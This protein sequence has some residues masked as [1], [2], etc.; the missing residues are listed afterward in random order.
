MSDHHYFTGSLPAL[1]TPFLNGELDTQALRDLV[2]W[3]LAEGSHGIVPCGTTGEAPTLSQDEYEA[4]IAICAEQA[5]GQFPV[6]AGCGANSTQKAL[7]LARDAQ[8]AGADAVLCVTPY[9]N[10]PPQE[11]LYIHFKTL[12][13]GIDIPIIVYNIPG[14]CSVDLY[15]ETLARLANDLP[16]I[17]GVKDASNDL[18]R[19][20]R[21]RR[22]VEG[23]F[24]QLSGEDATTAAFLGQGGQGCISA[25]ANVAPKLCAQMHE[26]WMRGHLDDFATLR[27]RIAP[28][29][30]ALFTETSPIPVKYAASRLGL[31]SDEVRL[32]LIPAS[33][34]CRRAVDQALDI[35]GL[36]PND[37]RA[38]SNAH[39]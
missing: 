39:G 16:R 7:G 9:Y 4:I 34:A 21:L 36:I 29:H 20:P 14:R 18:A 12:H 30:E 28:L 19:P 25:T 26:A 10:K 13:D 8:A 15:V 33:D 32:P 6:I 17:A 3:H 22:L 5:K 35:V 38:I 37:M 1:I 27:D 24:V 11:G 23:E 31:C 2:K